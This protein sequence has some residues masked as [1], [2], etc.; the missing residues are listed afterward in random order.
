MS[1]IPEYVA[2]DYSILN[3]HVEEGVVRARQIG[4]YQRS[5]VWRNFFKWGAIFLI[6]LGIT[7]VLLAYAYRIFVGTSP[8]DSRPPMFQDSAAKKAAA[9]L[10]QEGTVVEDFNKFTSINFNRGEFSNVVIGRKYEDENQSFPSSQWCY[11]QRPDDVEGSS[12]QVS[13]AKKVGQSVVDVDLS[14]ALADKHNISLADLQYA[15]SLCR[16][17]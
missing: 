13:L 5:L 8:L 12:F 9:A 11:M 3:Q 17:D 10:S 6:G 7:A 15:K 2:H 14:Q 1:N 4:N 16:F